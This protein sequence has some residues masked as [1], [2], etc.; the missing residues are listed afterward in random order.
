M[1]PIPA[2]KFKSI[3]DL[4]YSQSGLSIPAALF[5]DLGLLVSARLTV[6]LSSSLS[7]P[8]FFSSLQG[9]LQA[10][11]VD[12][13]GADLGV[14]AQGDSGG[15]MGSGGSAFSAGGRGGSIVD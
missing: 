15:A 13:V 6:L 12:S 1:S 4:N 5:P 14:P 11:E 10:M 9:L 7:R 3:L 2:H 8:H